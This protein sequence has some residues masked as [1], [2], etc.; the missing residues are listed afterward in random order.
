MKTAMKVLLAVSVLSAVAAPA[1]AQSSATTSETTAVTI[2]A[3][4]TIAP[5]AAMQFGSYVANSAAAGGTLVLS[6]AGAVTPTGFTAASGGAAASAAKFS[7]N[8]D[9]GRTFTMTF[10]NTALTSGG[11]SIPLSGLT[12]T[13]LTAIAA[14]GNTISVGGTLTIAAG[15]AAGVYG[16][17]VS[18]TVAYN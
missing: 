6:T 4:I 2:I 14:G 12:N 8:G 9:V 1:I 11:N 10:T 5:V 13:A 7:V 18:A 17:T 16:G 3:P 15:Q